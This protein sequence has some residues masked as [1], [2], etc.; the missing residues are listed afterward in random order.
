MSPSTR[1][2]ENISFGYE[3]V[4]SGLRRWGEERQAYAA[5]GYYTNGRDPPHELLHFTQMVWVPTAAIGCT[6]KKCVADQLG[7]GSVQESW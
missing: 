1:Y 7:S 6:R 4:E 3:N 5:G 2:G